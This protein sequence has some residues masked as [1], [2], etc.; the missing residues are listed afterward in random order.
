MKV[1]VLNQ[2]DITGYKEYAT[3]HKKFSG[4]KTLTK[5]Q[6]YTLSH[7][8]VGENIII[9]YTGSIQITSLVID[10][11]TVVSTAVPVNADPLVLPI[12]WSQSISLE[13]T[14]T[15]N[16]TISAVYMGT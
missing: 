12:E 4:Q 3:L 13:I 15:S 14:A 11:N 9:F 10:G 16:A 5:G 7:T 1:K 8:G 2:N 6:S